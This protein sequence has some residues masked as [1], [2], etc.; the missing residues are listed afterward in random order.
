V[1]LP[2]REAAPV[3]LIV[4]DLDDTLWSGVLMEGDAC[5]AVPDVV[6]FIRE[7][8]RKGVLHS[9]AS[10]ND[11]A[12]AAAH[13]EKSGLQELFLYPQ[14]G[15][16][17]KSHSVGHIAER[18]NIGLDA[19]LFI[20]DSDFELE[21]VR[22]AHP[23]I[24]TA[25]VARLP[26][27]RNGGL[28]DALPVTGESRRRRQMYR[29]DIR[30]RDAEQ[31]FADTP[32]AFLAT[33]HLRMRVAPATHADLERAEELVQRTNQLNST[34]RIFSEAELAAMIDARR[35]TLLVATLE[36]RF[37]DYGTV[38]LVVLEEGPERWTVELILVSCRV[39]SRGI[40]PILLDYLALRARD[41]G[42]SLAVAFRDTGRNR[43]MKVALMITGFV[44]AGDAP[45]RFVHPATGARQL[46]AWLDLSG[47]W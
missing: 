42:A 4:W 8:D 19:V 9:I 2:D 46:P 35:P 3:K 34:G 15:W 10:R 30:R 29:E 31:S 45:G 7:T 16:G 39:M 36:D 26:E 27:L 11:P 41:A 33:L 43:A 24:R 12:A 44:A 32:D 23:A 18:L 17:A 13:L 20:D 40:G 37:G 21:E 22:S 6:D 14:I 1:S 25:N 38:A 47:G 5:A 28:F